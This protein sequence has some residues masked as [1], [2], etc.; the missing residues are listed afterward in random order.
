MNDD[1]KAQLETALGQWLHDFGTNNELSQRSRILLGRPAVDP[2]AND[3][4][5]AK[6]AQH[7]LTL[8]LEIPIQWEGGLDNAMLA[9]CNEI[10]YLAGIKAIAKA[11]LDAREPLGAEAFE[12]YDKLYHAIYPRKTLA[13]RL[14]EDEPDAE[15]LCQSVADAPI[16]FETAINT[17]RIVRT[18]STAPELCIHNVMLGQQCPRC[19]RATNSL[20][21]QAVLDLSVGTNIAMFFTSAVDHIEKGGNYASGETELTDGTH[22]VITVSRTGLVRQG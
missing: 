20:L 11:Y 6:A 7:W 8:Q 2:K 21:A 14:D 9:A 5:I 13:Q 15:K 4:V 3:C 17:A 1:R 16:Q 18:G 22:V 19:P 10:R 12:V